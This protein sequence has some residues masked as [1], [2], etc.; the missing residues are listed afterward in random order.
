MKSYTVTIT[1]QTHAEDNLIKSQKLNIIKYLKTFF[2]NTEKFNYTWKENKCKK[3][4]L[5]T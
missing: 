1:F 5:N 3:T 2:W 4:E